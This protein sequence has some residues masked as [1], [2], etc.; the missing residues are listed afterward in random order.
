MVITHCKAK[1]LSCVYLHA[2]RKVAKA[3]ATLGYILF[4]VI[5]YHKVNSSYS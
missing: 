2:R 1:V 3:I 4:I 5:A